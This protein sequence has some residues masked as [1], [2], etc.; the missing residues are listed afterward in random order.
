MKKIVITGPESSGK[1]TLA[2]ILSEKFNSKIV[3][4]YAVEYL[5][6]TNGVYDFRD[7][8]KI[9]KGQILK[10]DSTFSNNKTNFLICDT[11]LI[12]IKIWSQVKYGR[13]SRKLLQ[14]IKNRHY[15][16]YLLCK[17]DIP[18]T[19]ARFRES[20]DDRDILFELYLKELKKYNK[21]YTII[22]GTKENRIKT[23]IEVLNKLQIE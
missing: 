20:P 2:E 12:T 21:K 5:I 6:Q 14:N 7:L 16:Y 10:E 13:V 15:D 22:S 11:D 1:T 19:Y 18:W 17:P 3:N 23:A 8:L 9:A 4:E